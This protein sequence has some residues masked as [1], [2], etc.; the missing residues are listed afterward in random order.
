MKIA[1]VTPSIPERLSMLEEVIQSV[2][3]QELQPHEHIIVVDHARRG[4]VPKINQIHK[5]SE[6][7]WLAP[8]ADDDLMMPNHLSTLAKGV[9]DNPDA[10]VVYTWCQTIGRGGW[11]PNAHFD[12]EA[13]K[14]V[15]F[16]PAAVLIRRSVLEEFGWWDENAPGGLEDWEMWK[17]L[18]EAGKKFICI[19]EVTWIYRFHGKQLTFGNL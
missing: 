3:D 5:A 13:L 17:K 7:E 15:N 14:K 4:V 2:N 9:E 19:P 1:V 16:I 6:C 10:D 8:I 11:S 18:S 12:A